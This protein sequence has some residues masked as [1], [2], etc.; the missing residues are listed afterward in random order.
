M[1]WKQ[2][3]KPNKKEITKIKKENQNIEELFKKAR[4]KTTL[5]T[6]AEE[7]VN[8]DVNET[9]KEEDN[10]ETENGNTETKNSDIFSKVDQS[11]DTSLADVIEKNKMIFLPKK[12]PYF[13]NG[14]FARQFEKQSISNYTCAIDSFLALGEAILLSSNVKSIQQ[15]IDFR[16]IFIG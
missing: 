6:N 12:I 15:A 2:Y 16:P 3:K 13:L 1:D 11:S 8:F 14:C 4:N 5:K 10:M 9:S 7:V